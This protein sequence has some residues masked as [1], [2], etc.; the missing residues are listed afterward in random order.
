M[1]TAPEEI[2]AEVVNVVQR[3]KDNEKTLDMIVK[4][5]NPTIQEHKGVI[6]AA[7]QLKK[8]IHLPV[9]YIVNFQEMK[10]AIKANNLRMFHE[11]KNKLILNIVTHG[12][13]LDKALNQF[14]AAKVKVYE[15]QGR[16]KEA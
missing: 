14:F 9:S 4:D 10:K 11:F 3:G 6:E 1:E 8:V 15:Q 2:D 13:I 12:E 16:A 7:N 5:M